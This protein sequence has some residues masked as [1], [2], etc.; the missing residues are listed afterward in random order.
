MLAIFKKEVRSFF[1]T[2]MGYLVVGLFLLLNGLFLWVFEGPY[3]LLEY[4][5]ADLSNFFAIAPWIFLFLIP[6]ICMRSFSE[7]RKLGTLELLYI[8]PT[9]LWQIVLGKFMGAIALVLIALLPTLLYVY[10]ISELGTTTGNLDLGL[11]WGSYFGMIFLIIAY[12]AIS[13]LISAL[14]ENQIVAFLISI[15][16]CF[17]LFYGFEA[18]AS[19]I[20]NGA[21]ALG[22]KSIGMKAHYDDMANGVLDSRDLV[23]FLSLGYFF[24]FL[25]QVYLKKR[26]R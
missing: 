21:L 11:I 14:S 1:T 10:A 4:G 25:T 24:L 26:E 5:F 3:N 13:L 12:T 17:C 20:D 8:K 9:T 23:Y 7:E 19:L 18:I 16:I 6:A 22:V 15:L 2:P